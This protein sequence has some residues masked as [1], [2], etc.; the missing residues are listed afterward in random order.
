I[1]GAG[2]WISLLGDGDTGWHIRTGQYILEHHSVPTTDLFS[3]S[4]PGAPWFAWEW[5]T[6]VIYA[7]LF[8]MGGFKGI[9]LFA[10]VLISI[11]ATVLLRYTLWRGA[12]PLVAISTTL[13]AVGASSIHFLARPH[14]FTLVLLPVC[15]WIVEADRRART[16]WLWALIPLTALWTNLHGGFF[17]WLA[18][19]GLVVAGCALE[20]WRGADRRSDIQR[21][22]MLFAGSAAASLVNPYGIRLQQHIFEFLRADWIKNLVQ[23]FQAP[24]FRNEGQFQYELLLV[25]GLVTAGLL[26]RRRRM[27][28]ALWV[29]FL[30]HCSLTSVRH[31]PIYAAL[32]APLIACQLS[33][34]WRTQAE[35]SSKSSAG[36]ILYQMGADLKDGFLRTS[37]WPAMLVGVLIALD[38]PLHWP[39]DFPQQMFPVAMI[40]R[41]RDLV[42]S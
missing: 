1:C 42:A 40:G 7:V 35:K 29:V 14:L 5:L 13:L 41:H 39:V 2:G 12:N 36:A 34:W 16:R 26:L 21:Y 31:A 27:V 3:F 9:V 22:G 19:L 15:W 4:R 18:C 37:L 20:A 6:D 25:A 24:T 8:R 23:E 33:H 11:Y 17:I 38:A 30:A 32:A 28:E 10:G